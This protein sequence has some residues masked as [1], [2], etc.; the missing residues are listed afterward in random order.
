MTGVLDIN[1]FPRAAELGKKLARHTN[2]LM[3][4]GVLLSAMQRFVEWPEDINRGGWKVYGVKWQ[5]KMIG[6]GKAA[7]L[8]EPEGEFVVNAGYSLMLPGAEIKSHVGYTSDVF[9]MHLGLI[10][11]DGDCALVVGGERC[12]WKKGEI[13]FFDDTVEHYAYNHTSRPR[14]VF[15]LDV[16]RVST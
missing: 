4:E 2:A 8:I 7:E 14:L 1:E 9:R 5:G 3:G 6:F 10:T 13:L 16:R 11:P 12:Q 15:L